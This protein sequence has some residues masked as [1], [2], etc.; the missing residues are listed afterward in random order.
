MKI[1]KNIG[2]V[3][4]M[5]RIIAGVALMLIVPLAFVGPESRWAFLG[6]LGLLPLTAGIV[7][8]CPRH[9]FLGPQHNAGNK[10]RINEEVEDYPE[11][12][13]C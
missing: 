12:A 6:L 5:V 4:R 9:A 3:S 1:Q 10:K 11:T 8:Y 7:G 2:T 13:C